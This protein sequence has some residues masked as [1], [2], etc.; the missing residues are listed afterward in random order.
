VYMHIKKTL[1]KNTKINDTYRHTPGSRVHTYIHRYISG[2]ANSDVIKRRRNAGQIF[3]KMSSNFLY[4]ACH[5]KARMHM[6]FV[7]HTSMYVLVPWTNN[8][9]LE[10]L[11]SACTPLYVQY[12]PCNQ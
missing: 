5:A 1:T 11:R 4:D 9:L 8:I 10:V 6:H 3:D 12:I 2:R 7:V